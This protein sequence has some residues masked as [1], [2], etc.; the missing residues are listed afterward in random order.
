MRMGNRGQ[1]FA[2]RRF[3]IL[4]ATLL[5]FVL[6]VPL[7]TRGPFGVTVLQ[8]LMA[9]LSVTAAWSVGAL[10][11]GWAVAL[12][13]GVTLLNVSTVISGNRLHVCFALAG[14][15]AFLTWV[16]GAVVTRLA[17]E[18]AVTF[19][20]LCGAATAYLLMGIAFAIGYGLIELISPGALGDLVRQ[21]VEESLTA[22]RAGSE[23]PRLLYFSLVTLSTLGYGDVTPTHDFVRMLAPLEAILGQLYLAIVIARMVALQLLGSP[24][25]AGEDGL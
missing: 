18:R 9:G 23:F 2:T 19:D 25:R 10:R 13:L 15:I 14:M 22:F 21:P 20:S 6:L 7:G 3:D 11:R 4:L 12:A 16:T 24:S 17:R 5:A 8:L 1:A